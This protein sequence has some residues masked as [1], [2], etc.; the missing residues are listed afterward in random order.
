MTTAGDYVDRH[1][2]PAGTWTVIAERNG[3]EVLST[4]VAQT[5][6]SGDHTLAL[7]D[8]AVPGA[9]LV[10]E[11]QFAADEQLDGGLTV[12]DPEPVTVTRASL[13]AGEMLTL[14]IPL[15]WW[16]FGVIIGLTL[17]LV[18]TVG[19]ILLRPWLRTTTRRR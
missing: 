14:G 18:A 2:A 16:L 6:G 7:T 11:A 15:P 12:S 8:L 19:V 4:T 17:G 10:V 1:G 3:T 9:T 5:T 13:S